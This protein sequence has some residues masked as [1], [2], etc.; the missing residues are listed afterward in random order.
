M[1]APA[2]RRAARNVLGRSAQTFAGLSATGIDSFT[3]R[4][5][6]HA[7]REKLQLRPH[8]LNSTILSQYVKKEDYLKITKS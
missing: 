6:F 7:W 1:I 2:N 8:Y 4:G 5:L 3:A